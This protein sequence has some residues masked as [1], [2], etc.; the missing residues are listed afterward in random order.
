[1]KRLRRRMHP[2]SHCAFDLIESGT[3]PPALMWFT[4]FILIIV[5]GQVS[6]ILLRSFHHSFLFESD[7]D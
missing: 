5:T 2:V 6:G 7:A 3:A 4:A 1:M